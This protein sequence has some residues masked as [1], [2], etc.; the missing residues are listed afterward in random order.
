M[1]QELHGTLK[2]ISE[3][4]LLLWCDSEPSSITLVQSI[5]AT[6]KQSEASMLQLIWVCWCSFLAL[7]PLLPPFVNICGLLVVFSRLNT[8]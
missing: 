6:W 3:D 5:R 4:H 1:E 2:A 7:R 8:F